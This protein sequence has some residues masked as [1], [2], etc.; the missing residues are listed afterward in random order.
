M[1][2]DVKWEDL[3]KEALSLV[4]QELVTGEVSGAQV[5]MAKFVLELA[6][7][8]VWA[9]KMTAEQVVQNIQNRV[10][11]PSLQ[12]PPGNFDTGSVP[13]KRDLSPSVTWGDTQAKVVGGVLVSGDS[14]ADKK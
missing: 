13:E 14:A 6:A 11:P 7:K 10:N 3:E 8:Y 9:E 12:P 5:S 2:E 1:S 4:Y